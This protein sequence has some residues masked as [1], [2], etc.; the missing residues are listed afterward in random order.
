MSWNHVTVSSCGVD[1]GWFYRVTSEFYV[2]CPEFSVYFNKGQIFI[3]FLCLKRFRVRHD[4]SHHIALRYCKGADFSSCWGVIREGSF[5]ELKLTEKDSL[6]KELNSLRK[7]WRSLEMRQ[8][9][10]PIS[11]QKNLSL[12]PLLN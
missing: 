5:L 9:S 12:I 10:T 1:L 7:E 4:I 3:H 2:H 11:L 6:Y 8:S